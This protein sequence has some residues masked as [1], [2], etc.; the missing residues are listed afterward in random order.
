MPTIQLDGTAISYVVKHSPRRTRVSLVVL[1][2]SVEVRMPQS[3]PADYAETYLVEK[4]EWVLKHVR[5]HRERPLPPEISFAKDDVL[6]ILGK[7]CR[8]I[9]TSGSKTQF[10]LKGEILHL[11]RHPRATKKF[12]AQKLKDFYAQQLLQYLET[13]IPF[14]VSKG[15]D[16]PKGL[17]VREY[18]R[19]WAAC[20]SD[21]SLRFN[22]KLGLA[23]P[24]VID[25]VLVHE[26]VH[27]RIRNHSKLFWATVTK[28]IPNRKELD[29]WLKENSSGL[30]VRIRD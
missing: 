6:P 24:E 30:D 16:F 15:L 11:Q 22:W 14:F 1:G 3:L 7:E 19:K 13:R 8:M 28:Y 9:V 12:L 2:D 25:L 5:K 10:E 20:L 21:N 29:T 26:L 4:K 23:P 17:S 27:L 18:K